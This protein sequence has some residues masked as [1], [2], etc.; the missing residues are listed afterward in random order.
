LAKF[1]LDEWGDEAYIDLILTNGNISSELGISEDEFC[2]KF[3][4]YI[5]KS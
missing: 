5:D 2:A 3:Q 1:I 4:L